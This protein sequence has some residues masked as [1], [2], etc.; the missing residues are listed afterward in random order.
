MNRRQFIASGLAT[1]L[2]SGLALGAG[3]AFAG[4]AMF[5]TTRGVAIEGYDPV[6]Y[7]AGEGPTRGRRD[8]SLMWKGAV[9]H[10]STR[11]HRD[12]F[13]LNPWPLAPRYG[14]YCAYSM[15]QGRLIPASPRAWH[16]AG[17]RLYLIRDAA[18]HERWRADIAGNIARADVNWPGLL[19]TQGS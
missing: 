8:I 9:W 11:A 12:M 13:E 10:F 17:G 4:R 3:P 2:A 7:F 6:S 16:L 14:A 5:C 1:G 19:L 15:S 18:A